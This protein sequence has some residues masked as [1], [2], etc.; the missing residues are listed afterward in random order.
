MIS[1]RSAPTIT[2]TGA[3]KHSTLTIRTHTHTH[4]EEKEDT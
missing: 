2:A 1:R 3:V 4:T